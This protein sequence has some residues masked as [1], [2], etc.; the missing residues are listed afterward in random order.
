MVIKYSLKVTNVMANCD[1]KTNTKQK[2]KKFTQKRARWF[3]GLKRVL[4]LFFKKP[5]YVFLGEKPQTGA[6]IIS[7]HEGSFGPMTTE[8]YADFPV[9]FWGTYEMNAGLK[10]VYKYLSKV[11]YHQKMHWP[12][13]I[14]RL[15]CIIAAPLVNLFYKGLRLVSTYPDVRFWQTLK[16]SVQILEEGDNIV[17]FPEDSSKGY[18]GKLTSFFAGFAALGELCLKRG[19]DVPV[20]VSYLQ[21]KKHVYVYD[22]PIMYSQLKARYASRDEMAHALLNRCNELGQMNAKASDANNGD[23]TK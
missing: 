16:H 22:E 9:R 10:S 15:F 1:M 23:V 19:I 4:R 13:W 17:I 3:R 8:I 6:I 12:L 11:Y 14:A 18:F 2:T 5:R 7:N 20:Y 21:H